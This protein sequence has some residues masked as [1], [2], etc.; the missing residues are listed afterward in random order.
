MIITRSGTGT[1]L[2]LAGGT[3]TGDIQMQLNRLRT[4]NLQLREGAADN[5]QIR[6]AVDAAYLNL[7]LENLVLNAGIISLGNTV[8]VNARNIDGGIMTLGARDAGVA[9]LEVARLQG[10]ADPYF[11][12]TRPM[13]L[14]PAAVPGTLVEGHFG[15]DSALDKLWY[16]DAGATRQIPTLISS[17][18]V[19]NAGANRQI[20]TGFKCSLVIV[21]DSIAYLLISQR[22]DGNTRLHITPAIA[23][24]QGDVLLHATD[25]FVVDGNPANAN[26]VTYTYWAI[27]D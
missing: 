18:Y 17:T 4:T 24:N 5:L 7:Y 15:Y 12:A 8:S 11:Q 27:S 3:M 21:T 19:G 20:T 25:G 9:I 1:F 23:F 16:R 6:N 13:V 10:A 26:A 2:P 14:L 22:A